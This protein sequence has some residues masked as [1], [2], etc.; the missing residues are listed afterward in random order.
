[1]NLEDVKEDFPDG[2]KS[3]NAHS[4]CGLASTKAAAKG[5]IKLLKPATRVGSNVCPTSL[6]LALVGLNCPTGVQVLCLPHMIGQV[7]HAFHVL[8]TF[9]ALVRSGLYVGSTGLLF[10]IR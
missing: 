2:G 1:M 5:H 9:Q 8:M 10:N 6:L 4:K 3:V 7:E